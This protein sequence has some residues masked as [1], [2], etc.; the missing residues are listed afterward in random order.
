MGSSTEFLNASDAASRLGVSAKALRL[1]EQRGLIVPVRTAAGWRTYGPE[2]MARAGEIVAM[3]ALGLS[4]AQVQRVLAGDPRGLEASLAAHQGVLE[5]RLQQLA[6]MLDRVRQLRESL[7]RGEVPGTGALAELL[8]AEAPISL[9]FELPW[10]WGGETFELRQI[11][12]LSYI[13]GPLGSGK[14]RLAQ[15][16]TEALPGALFLGLDRLVDGVAAEARMDADAA[17]RERVE[18]TLGWLIEDGASASDA[19]TALVA[20][21]EAA[22]PTVL[23]IDML[24]QG[25]EQSSQEAV[26]AH[27]R[28]RGPGARPVFAMTRS[29]AV[30]DLAAVG[31]DEAII[32]CPANHS[33]PTLVAPYPGATGYEAVATCLA[34][35]E[36]RARTEGIIATRPQVA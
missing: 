17:L 16:L 24:E 11:K 32:L 18:R 10:P 8:G 22:W 2:Q 5:G 25:L 34:T 36:V 30:L 6:G 23:V 20:G 4:L 35:P 26:V 7:S 1:Y 19:L 27:L 12:P 9:S 33:P 31:P 3:R 28:H 14:T 21:L 13:I 29:N 15:K